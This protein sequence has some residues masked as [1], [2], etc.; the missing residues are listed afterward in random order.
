MRTVV[1]V[2]AFILDE[3]GPMSTMKLEKLAFYSQAHCLVTEGRCLFNEDFQAWV[4]GPVAPALYREHRGMFL[5]HPG[6]LARAVRG[7]EPLEPR[8]RDEVRAACSR[9]A[10]LTGNQLSAMTHGEDLW[11]MAREGCGPSDHCERVISKESMRRY[12]S[13]HRAWELAP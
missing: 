9:L 5:I 7:H 4:N 8:V 13:Q 3:Y 12:Y 10:T 6:D 1:D 11:R 2:A